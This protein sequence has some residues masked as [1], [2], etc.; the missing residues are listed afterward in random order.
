MA[1]PTVYN[2]IL[3]QDF[4]VIPITVPKRYNIQRTELYSGSQPV[5]GSGYKIWTAIHTNENLRLG[6]NRIYPTNSFDGTYQHVIWKSIDSRYYRFPN[7]SIA[8]LEHVNS[9]FTY[10]YLNVSASIIQIPQHNF[11]EGIYPGSVEITSSLGFNLTDDHNGNLYDPSISTGSFTTSHNLIGWW[12]FNDR[13]RLKNSDQVHNGTVTFKS[14][15]FADDNRSTYKKCAFTKGSAYHASTGSQ[16][17]GDDLWLD[18]NLTNGDADSYIL[19]NNRSDLNFPD[20]QDF[21]IAFWASGFDIAYGPII[22]KNG[23]IRKE[24]FGSGYVNKSGGPIASN[25]VYSQSYFNESTNVYPYEFNISGS[26][27]RMHFLR[28]DGINLLRLSSSASFVGTD[29]PRHVCVTKSGSMCYLYIDGGLNTSGS[30]RTNNPVNQHALMFG[31]RDLISTEP[32]TS[33]LNDVRFYNR[34]FSIGQIQTLANSSSLSMIQTAVAGNVFYKNGTVVVSSHHPK[35]N[36][37]FNYDFTLK[38]RNTHTIYQYETVIRIPKGSFNLT[39]NPTALQSPYTDLLINEMTASSNPNA[40]L[41]PY[42]TSI[43]LYND[44]KELLAVAKLNRPLKMRS[45]VDINVI[46]RWDM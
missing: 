15:I 22:S 38:Y 12:N 1:I 33:L 31:S 28:S 44:E 11:G 21:T 24:T 4:S 26:G 30:D 36:N 8:S 29:G 20:N 17:L 16:I 40:D 2:S 37:V 32:A 35:Y 42:A 13:F 6:T 34:A 19:T 23:V 18:F 45:D 10:K 7:D 43:G 14:N 5:T 27:G 39:M 9:R 41:Y 46:A 3:T 25:Q